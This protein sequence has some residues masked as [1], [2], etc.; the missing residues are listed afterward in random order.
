MGQISVV[1]CLRDK[2]GSLNHLLDAMLRMSDQSYSTST[3]LMIQYLCIVP[4]ETL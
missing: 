4:C 3:L 1:F 2:K